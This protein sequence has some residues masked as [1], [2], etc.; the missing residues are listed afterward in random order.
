M[1]KRA[2]SVRAPPREFTQRRA[3]LQ[4][5]PKKTD[6]VLTPSARPRASTEAVPAVSTRGPNRPDDSRWSQQTL[7]MWKPILTLWWSI[8]ILMTCAAACLVLGILVYR[9]STE[10]SVYR[11]VYDG[12]GAIAANQEG[13]SVARLSNCHLASLADANSFSG[14]RTC[15]V[16]IK[17]EKDFAADGHLFYELDP[18]YQ[19]HRRLVASQQP[20]QLLDIW[21]Q[22]SYGTTECEPLIS[23]TSDVCFGSVCNGTVRERELYPC[24]LVANTMFNDIFWLHSGS[25]PSGVSLGHSDMNSQGIARTF[26]TF[27]VVNPTLTLDLG[28]YLPIWNNPNFSRIIPAPGAANPPII[29][30]DY[31]NSTAWTTTQPP[32]VGLENE[33]FRVWIDIAATPSVR[34][35]YGRIDK[36][37]LLQGTTLTFAVQSN[38]FAH[39]G[40][41]AIVLAELGWFGSENRPL[42]VAF[43][44]TGSLCAF[45]GLV[46][47][48]RALRNPRKLGDVSALKWKLH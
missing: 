43:I 47:L 38:F 48:V 22:D 5:S 26:L 32:G 21:T 6:S 17:L 40:T 10:L 37:K 27:N 23:A 24:G 42:G 34:K 31:T 35:L 44:V 8:G 12:P 29:T 16:T 4:F 9:G 30:A 2:E 18:F 45:A 7:P 28:T 20:S 25:V 46:F 13:G 19:N 3:S 15:F 11:V 14:A 1:S 33:W 36:S 41:K 39:E